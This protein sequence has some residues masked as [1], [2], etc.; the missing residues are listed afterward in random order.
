MLSG[1]STSACALPGRKSSHR[2]I[3]LWSGN[4][5]EQTLS[6]PNIMMKFYGTRSDFRV[7]NGGGFSG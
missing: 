6:I 4:Y 1:Q 3:G 7:H 5:Y 2:E